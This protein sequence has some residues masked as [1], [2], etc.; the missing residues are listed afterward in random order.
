MAGH[1]MSEAL[2]SASHLIESL[3]ARLRY[4]TVSTLCE[5]DR[6]KPAGD[7]SGGPLTVV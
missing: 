1:F 2:A 5:W 3:T 7:A 4:V 6:R